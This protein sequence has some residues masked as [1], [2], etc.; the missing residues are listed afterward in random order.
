MSLNIDNNT[1][2]E[3]IATL[4]GI[5]LTDQ[6]VHVYIGLLK[7][8][9]ADAS[10]IAKEISIKRTTVY[11]ILDKLISNGVVTVLE[12]GKKRLYTPIKPSGL[13]SLYERKL[14][15]LSKIIPS[16]ENIQGKLVEGYGVRFIRSEKELET[17]YENI[18]EEYKGK[19][20]FIIGDVSSFINLDREF[21]LNYRKKRAANN[22]RTKLLL[23][24]KSKSEVGQDDPGLLR[25]FK[26]LP[27]KYHFK[28]TID[29][30]DNK[31]VIIGP[32]VK[33]LAVV[34]EVP[35]MVDIFRSVF[36]SLWEVLPD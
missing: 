12:Q 7:L 21:F 20:F 31:I 33:A 2:S 10:S 24:H 4:K 11:P 23:T 35:P 1:S 26:Y 19:E 34:I 25:S 8:G 6:E 36:M 22:I 5:G 27:E 18:I 15:T 28:S 32:E 29:I 17:F 16:L 14:Q 9:G 13:V 3:N 30:Y